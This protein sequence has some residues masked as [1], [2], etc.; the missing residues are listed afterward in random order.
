MR[1]LRIYHAGRDPSSR[2]RDRALVRAGAEVILVVPRSWPGPDDGL[3]DESFPII[4]LDVTRPGDVNRHRWRG[5]L[6]AV[7]HR[8][9]PDVVDIHEEPVSLAARQWLAASAGRPVVM[10]TAQNLDK[11]WPPP[12]AGYERSALRSVSGFYACSRQ[13]ASVLRGKGF[14]GPIHV[15]PLGVDPTVFSRGDQRLP[16]AEVVL[17]LAGRLVPEKGALDALE[18]LAAVQARH[19]ARLV[20]VGSGPQ[21]DEF[22]RRMDE[23]SLRSSVERHAWVDAPQLAALYG[24]AHVVLVPSRATATWVEQFGRVVVEGWA[25]GAVPAAY[26]SGSLPDVVGAGG[27]VVPE[28]DT[29]ALAH[30]VLELIELPERWQQPRTSPPGGWATWEDVAAAQV[31]LYRLAAEGS[32]PRAAI[33]R[34]AAR[35]EFGPPARTPVSDR[36]LALPVLRTSRL[37]HRLLEQR[38]NF[39]G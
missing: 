9:A 22:T 17:L 20:I 35:E 28:G 27:L 10:Y 16:T 4:E 33:G 26:A 34:Q 38:R 3:Q 36:P 21:E 25:C 2:A 1:V 15:L 32:P 13:A 5:D 12:F 39:R 6:A 14:A 7:L 30:G 29:G 19:R 18:V 31:E 37:L 8:S 23:M 11:R 24:K